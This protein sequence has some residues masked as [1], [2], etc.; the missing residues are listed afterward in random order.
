MYKVTGKQKFGGVWANG[1]PLVAFNNGV[2]YVAT[3]EAA[4]ALKGLGYTV[5]GE[6]EAPATPPDPL[7]G[8]KV[9]ELKAYAA[10]KGID[11]KDATKK[12]DILAA[13]RAAEA[14]QD[15]TPPDPGNT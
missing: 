10:E 14:D 7:A 12:A 2:G 8:M 13:I 1:K 3:E 5:E 6:P 9:D 15:A 4:N 11:L